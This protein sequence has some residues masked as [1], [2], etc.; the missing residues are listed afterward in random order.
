MA[1]AEVLKA[2]HAVDERIKS[3]DDKVALVVDSGQAILD[4]LTLVQLDEKETKAAV[5]Q[6]ARDVGQ[7][8]R[9][10]LF[11]SLM[12]SLSLTR[13]CSNP[14]MGEPSQMAFPIRPIHK[15]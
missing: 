6:T 3:V 7:I 12:L 2:T 15:P 14:V 4:Q 13:H 10:H 5:Q 9:S 8:K 11:A 1:T